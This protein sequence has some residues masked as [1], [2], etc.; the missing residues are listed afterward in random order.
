MKDFG[1]PP[2]FPKEEEPSLTEEVV[3]PADPTK[4]AKKVKSK[5]LAKSGT[6]KYQWQIMKSIG[7]QDEEIKK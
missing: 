6:L 1:Y 4:K 2:Q 7:M 5:V 3:N